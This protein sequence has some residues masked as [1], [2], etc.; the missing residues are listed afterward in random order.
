MGASGEGN[1]LCKKVRGK[2]IQTF[3]GCWRTITR[4]GYFLQKC[5]NHSAAESKTSAFLF[6][7]LR[8]LIDTARV[9]ES[10]TRHKWQKCH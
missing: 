8:F 2:K 10:L 1:G 3:F 4:V 5:P 9:A 6:Q 7:D